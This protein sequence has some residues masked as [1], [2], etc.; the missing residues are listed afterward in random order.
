MFKL[1][2]LFFLV[3]AVVGKV[4]VKRESPD[5][6]E[7]TEI[8]LSPTLYSTSII[9]EPTLAKVGDLVHSVPTAVSHQSSTIVHNRA[10]VVTPIV[11]PAVKTHVT[12]VISSYLSPVVR[13]YPDIYPYNYYYNFY[14]YN[15]YKSIY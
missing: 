15:T 13:S 11:A 10:N 6:L 2:A 8:H 7:S 1:V 5:N 3:T 9:H 4:T 14:P 12:P